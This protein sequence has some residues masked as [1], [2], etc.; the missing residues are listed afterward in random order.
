[1]KKSNREKFQMV[2]TFLMEEIDVLK[3]QYKKI[4]KVAE[5]SFEI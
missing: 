5:D 2:I 4:V 1:M 3:L